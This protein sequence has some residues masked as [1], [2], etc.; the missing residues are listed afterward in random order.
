MKVQWQ[1]VD[2]ETKKTI[3]VGEEFELI[4]FMKRYFDEGKPISWDEAVIF[5]GDPLSLKNPIGILNYPD[6][7]KE[8]P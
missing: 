1:L 8:T 7:K 5:Y 3:S 4:D 2:I 6:I